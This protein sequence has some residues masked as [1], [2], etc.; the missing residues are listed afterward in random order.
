MFTYEPFL[1]FL[2]SSLSA[3]APF[4]N[5]PDSKAVWMAAQPLLRESEF[6]SDYHADKE[7]DADFPFWKG[8]SSSGKRQ[9]CWPLFVAFL[10][11]LTTGLL[12]SVVFFSILPRKPWTI[13]CLQKTSQPSPVLRDL[14]ITYHEQQFN[15]SFFK[16]TI[17]RQDGSPEVDAAW[18]D[19][20][21]DCKRYRNFPRV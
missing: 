7:G 13:S 2:W 9:S 19:L 21:A 14:E 1:C 11:G 12:L 10:F 5:L 16:E 4:D 6:F 18:A 8:N 3:H 15:G 20:G 17:Y